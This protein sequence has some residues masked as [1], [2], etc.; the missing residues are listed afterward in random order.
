MRFR[1]AT[2]LIAAGRGSRQSTRA[3]ARNPGFQDAG[4]EF[5]QFVAVAVY[6]AVVVRLQDPLGKVVKHTAYGVA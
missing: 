4:D 2:Q 1:V 6:L 5:R 3:L